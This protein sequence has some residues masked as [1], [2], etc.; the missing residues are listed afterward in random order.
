MVFEAAR[1]A[2]YLPDDV[3]AVHVSFGTVLG[4]DGRPF[5]TRAGDT[6]RLTSLLD[7]AVEQAKITVA[8]KNPSLD[9]ATLAFRAVE[10]GIGAIKYAD[11]S[12]GRT[13]DYVFDLDRMVSLQG[14]TGVYLQYAHARIQSI[15]GKVPADV[16]AVVS[17][18]QP[19]DPAERRLAILL[20][21][22]DDALCAARENYEPHRLC[23]YLYSVAQAFTDFY[24]AC[25]VLKAPTKELIAN[26]VALCQLTGRTLELGLGLLGVA[27]PDR[28]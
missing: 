22:L 10:V 28:L 5:K 16:S 19:L 4:P 21:G 26:R 9:D 25:P 7:E 1:R 20:D 15:L 3:E 6:V 24:E 23:G 12:V 14:N 13:R 27:A 17:T 11:L 18:S 8:E 2:G